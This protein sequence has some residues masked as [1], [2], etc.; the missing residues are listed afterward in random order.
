MRCGARRK[1]TGTFDQMSTEPQF[2]ENDPGL[3][4]THIASLGDG[5][6]VFDGRPGAGK[7]YLARTTASCFDRAA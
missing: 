2:I 3:L 7:S 1:L 5:L 6:V 4:A